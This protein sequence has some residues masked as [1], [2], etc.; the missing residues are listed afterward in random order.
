VP[1]WW[2]LD[3]GES[4]WLSRVEIVWEYPRQ[5]IGH[6]YGYKIAVSDEAAPS[7]PAIDNSSNQSTSKTQ[8]A[9]FAPQTA[10]RYVRITVTSLPPDTKGLPP[11]DTWAS[12]VEVRVFGH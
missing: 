12:I 9:T 8:V 1:Q 2:Q 10:G 6:P 5:A 3:L 11:L 4:H 7:V